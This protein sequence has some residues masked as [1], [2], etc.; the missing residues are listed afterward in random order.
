MAAY[1]DF[2]LVIISAVMACSANKAA[3]KAKKTKK[4]SETKDN[5]NI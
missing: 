4:V 1:I 5:E 3:A 2:F